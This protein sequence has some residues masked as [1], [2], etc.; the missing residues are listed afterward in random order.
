MNRERDMKRY[1]G[2]ARRYLGQQRKRTVLTIVAVVLSVALITSAGVFAQSIRELGVENVRE[3]FGGFYGR[4]SNLSGEEVERLRLHAAV[5]KAGSLVY[6]GT[7]SLTPELSVTMIAPDNQWIET[8][9]FALSAGR[10]PSQPGEVA[11]ERWIFQAARR[12]AS[13]GDVV[14]LEV[15][16]VAHER[17]AGGRSTGQEAPGGNPVPA[18]TGVPAP[19]ELTVVGFIDPSSGGVASGTSTAVVTQ[20]E[21]AAILPAAPRFTAAFTTRSELEPQEAIASVARSDRKSVV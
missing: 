4:L 13:I 17:S 7:A 20:S 9:G 12:P 16:P 3:R 15:Q 6:V 19:R 2:L 14:K 11:V 10:F 8:Q 5:A 18:A 21:A 1:T